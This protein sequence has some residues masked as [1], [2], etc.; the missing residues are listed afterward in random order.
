MVLKRSSPWYLQEYTLLTPKIMKNSE[1]PWRSCSST[2]RLWSFSESSAALGF[3]FRCGFGHVA[4]VIRTPRARFD[5]SVITTVPNVSYHA[6]TKEPDEIVLV[7]NPTDLPDP[8][9]LD[10][11]EE[12]FIKASIITKADYVGNVMSCVLK[13][14]GKS[15]I[16]PISLLNV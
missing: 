12:P 5:M 7:N 8:S 2:M 10:H 13:S 3:E 16:K 15:R 11:V 9:I 4:P 1:T 6:Y 14:V